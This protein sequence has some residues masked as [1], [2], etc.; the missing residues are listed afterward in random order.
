M[1]TKTRTYRT[2]VPATPDALYAWHDSPGAFERLSPP[3][4]EVEILSA[5]GTIRPG[6]RKQL[7]IPLAGP[8]G[9]TWEL[10]HSDD[11]DATGFVDTQVKGPFRTWRHEHRFRSDGHGMAILEDRLEYGLPFG[12]IGQAVASSKVDAELDRLFELRHARTRIDLARLH[13]DDSDRPLRIAVTG[14]TGLV[15]ERLVGFL[16]AGGHEVYRVVRSEPRDDQEIFWN[17][18]AGQ[19]DAAGLEALDAVVHLAGVSISGGLWTEKRKKAIRES[20]VKGTDLLARTLAGLKTP[21][22]VFV[23][24]SGV[25]YYGD[26]GDR[27]STEGTPS[28]EGFLTEV[29]RAWEA[30]A[31]P[32]AEAGIRVV[33]PRFGIVLAGEGGMLPLISLPF[34][35]GL[36]G[37]L[38]NG[39]QWMSWIALD[40]LVGVLYE[41]ILNN[42][43]SGPINATAPEPVTNTEFTKTLG[44]VLK[45]PTLF[46]V[47]A[48]AARAVGGLLAKELILYSQRVV[49]ARLEEIGFHFAF[50][51]LEPALRH[52]LGRYDG[53]RAS[54]EVSAGGANTD[55]A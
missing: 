15:G 6:D 35:L 33:H 25:N 37:P 12:P 41:T 8:L 3:W 17:P 16:R 38:G 11:V 30:A 52:E 13:R 23:S 47:P 55:A 22:K 32:A 53:H 54:D 48:F 49:P 18:S 28:G 46:R 10:V 9:I 45:R 5:T 4:R 14:S 43:L 36:G 7:R 29:T 50:P 31:A 19:I 34:K 42:D 2:P 24:T 26:G 27:V 39:R 20:R 40:D 51:T 1:S 44:T 21:P